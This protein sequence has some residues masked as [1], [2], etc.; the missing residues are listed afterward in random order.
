MAMLMI[1]MLLGPGLAAAITYAVK[2]RPIWC[3]S[4]F[5]GWLP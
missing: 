3:R 2:T 1:A 5:M 4:A